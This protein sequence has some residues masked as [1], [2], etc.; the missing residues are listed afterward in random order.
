MS[1]NTPSQAG[2][3]AGRAW[4]LGD[5]LDTD[6]HM[7]SDLGNFK[8]GNLRVTNRPQAVAIF[9]ALNGRT[10]AASLGS[11]SRFAMRNS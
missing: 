1:A 4:K 6:M 11:R 2:T 8:H 7:A 9:S 10:R 3:H 5:N